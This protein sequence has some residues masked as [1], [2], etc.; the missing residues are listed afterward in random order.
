ML[1]KLGVLLILALILINLTGCYEIRRNKE[2]KEQRVFWGNKNEV[3]GFL[4]SPQAKAERWIVEAL[5][6]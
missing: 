2:A 5:G 4:N 1:R 3:I 6:E